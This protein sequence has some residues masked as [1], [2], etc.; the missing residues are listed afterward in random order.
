MAVDASIAAADIHTATNAW[1]HQ[2][3][4]YSQKYCSNAEASV[5]DSPAPSR[6][7]L[8]SS[9]CNWNVSQL[10]AQ[11]LRRL[12]VDRQRLAMPHRAVAAHL[13][14]T[15]PEMRLLPQGPSV[16]ITPPGVTPASQAVDAVR[17]ICPATLQR[18]WNLAGG[19]QSSGSLVCECNSIGRE[20]RH[21]VLRT[22]NWGQQQMYSPVSATLAIVGKRAAGKQHSINFTPLLLRRRRSPRRLDTQG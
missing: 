14:L 4:G 20:A 17:Y 12:K 9:I 19:C 1:A 3:G 13:F 22:G 16:R 18:F 10:S 21:F 2:L 8:Q 6:E 7:N 15:Y 11:E 5:A